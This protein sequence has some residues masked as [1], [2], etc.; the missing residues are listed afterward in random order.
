MSLLLPSLHEPV[1]VD[2][3]FWNDQWNG[4]LCF[5]PEYLPGVMAKVRALEAMSIED[6]RLSHKAA[7]DAQ[8]TS[9]VKANGLAT[10]VI[11]GMMSKTGTSMDPSG[12]TV[13]A[14]HAIRKAVTN[15]DVKGI[16]LWI[17]SGGG[18]S[19]GTQELFSEVAKAAQAKPLYVAGEDIIGSAAYW[20]AAGAKRIFL[21]EAGRGGSIGSYMMLV[22]S[23][24]AAQQDGL[25]YHRVR[26]G[27]NKGI[28]AEGV[29]ITESDLAVMQKIIT[30]G[31]SLFVQ[32]IA[33]GRG[34][35]LEKAQSWATGE[36]YSAR[37]CLSMGLIDAIGTPEECLAALA[38]AVKGTVHVSMSSGSKSMKPSQIRSLCGIGAD[39]SAADTAFVMKMADI[40]DLDETKLSMEY[41]K[42]LKAQN[43][44][45]KAEQ[46]SEKAKADAALAQAKA[47]AAQ[48]LADT[49]KANAAAALLKGLS[50]GGN[51]APGGA[52]KAGEASVSPVEQMQELVDAYC[53]K[54]PGTR[55]ITAYTKILGTRPDLAKS[56]QEFQKTS[57]NSIA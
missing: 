51:K 15:A 12:S 7:V 1:L 36:T 21:N 19:A 44:A 35:S 22:D 40:D 2:P 23:S 28:G 48:T 3:V 26:F 8:M 6:R 49:S 20:A 33:Q 9:E 25:I 45:L 10:I 57:A 47:E 54:H 46:A 27:K 37:E 55:P 56:I 32:S 11:R 31:G 4:E 43:S 42:E 53:D 50:T 39:A 17:E 52:E 14:R 5:A 13:A 30:D 41:A 18:F 34:V 16:R 29:A 38:E 24:Q